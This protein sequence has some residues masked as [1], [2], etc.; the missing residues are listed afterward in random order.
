MSQY[1]KIW[2]V[3]CLF[4]GALVGYPCRVRKTGKVALME[5]HDRIIRWSHDAV[6]RGEIQRP[7]R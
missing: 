6:E 7:I 1:P 5:H 4:C 3:P 2:R